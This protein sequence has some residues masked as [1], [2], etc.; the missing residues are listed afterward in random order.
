MSMVQDGSHSVVVLISL[1]SYPT[2][3]AAILADSYFERLSTYH[4]GY[5]II[6][7]DGE[8]P[9]KVCRGDAEAPGL[10]D[11]PVTVHTSTSKA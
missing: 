3:S 2:L 7:E 11:R 4:M 6:V 10:T 5:N 9:S 1:V 8:S